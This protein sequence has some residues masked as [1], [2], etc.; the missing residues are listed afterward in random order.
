MKL[1]ELNVSTSLWLICKCVEFCMTDF[2]THILI[3]IFDLAS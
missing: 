1:C 3:V 2:T